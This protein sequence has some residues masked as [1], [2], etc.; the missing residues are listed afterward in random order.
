M[1]YLLPEIDKNAASFAIKFPA[2]IADACAS[3]LNKTDGFHA[4]YRRVVSL[5]AWRDR[6]FERDYSKP[7][8]SLFLEAQND[9]LLSIVLA[10]SSMWRP[11]LQ[12]LRSCLENILNT[13]YY[14]DHPIE[15]IL[16]EN[17]EYRMS[18][19]ELITYFGQHPSI[20]T[21]K[22]LPDVLNHIRQEYSVLSNAVH[23]SA[24]S[25]HMTKGG[26]ISITFSSDVDFNQW[27]KR[28][29]STLM[30]LNLFLLDLYSTKLMGAQNIDL[31]KAISLAIPSHYHNN[32][33][34]HLKVHLFS[35]D[36]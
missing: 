5:Q 17:A 6:L 21:Y 15:L 30:W 2:E 25:F 19:A 18:F 20:T 14:A 12:S 26:S 31:R 9:A 28:H 4:S 16:W 34:K 7:V 13:S 10:H 36:L 29:T 23:A 24:R 33:A 1:K 11:A 3:R 22:G 27:N 32:I 8:S 35:T